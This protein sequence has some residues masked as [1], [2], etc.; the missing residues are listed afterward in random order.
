LQRTR[1]RPKL[2]AV[3]LAFHKYEGLGNDFLVV[4]A[5]SREERFDAAQARAICDRHRGIGADGVLSVGR[6]SAGAF[7]RVVN[8]DGSRPEMCGN[9]IRCAVLHLARSG[10]IGNETV[11]IA[12]DAGPH[13]CT[14]LALDDERRTARVRVAMRPY[15]LTP[16][17]AWLA[18][19]TERLDAE[20]AIDGR[21]LSGTAVSMGNPHLVI[22]D[23]ERQ[24]AVA[25]APRL[26]RHPLFPARVN[27]GL[28]ELTGAR[29]IGLRV[30]ERGV[31]FTE[32]CGTGAC[33]AAAA[34]VETGRMARGEPIEV[35]LPGGVLTIVVGERGAP[36]SMTGPARFVFQGDTG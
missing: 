23:A 36:V 35:S 12:T 20:I 30:F 22:F 1:T 11:A 27:V 7:M 8:A 21:A 29:A 28:A 5:R 16:D 3:S 33:A 2:C 34:A 31:G 25:L 24:G 10:E 6:D 26:E 9:G 19:E 17:A 14:L 18:S 4:A 13:E 32:A 15:S